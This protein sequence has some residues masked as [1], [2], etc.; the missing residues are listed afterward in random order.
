MTSPAART[1][2]DVR[3][4]QRTLGNQA[5]GRLLAHTASRRSGHERGHVAGPALIQPARV[6]IDGK[7]VELGFKSTTELNTMLSTHKDKTAEITAEIEKRREAQEFVNEFW[8]ARDTD[9][10]RGTHTPNFKE[11]TYKQVCQRLDV[12]IDEPY[13]LDQGSLSFCGSSAFLS[14]F[15]ARSPVDFVGYVL[16]LCSAG[17]AKMGNAVVDTA[18]TFESP[19]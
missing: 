8:T 2:G 13:S 15:L 18:S 4:L 16:S 17:V 14:S 1:N 3:L 12:L 6:E 19:K 7:T 10:T 11:V 5:V 9:G